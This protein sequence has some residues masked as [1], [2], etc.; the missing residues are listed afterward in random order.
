[1]HEAGVAFLLLVHVEILSFQV[2]LLGSKNEIMRGNQQP[3]AGG[4]L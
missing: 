2:Y 4:V 3:L 1:M